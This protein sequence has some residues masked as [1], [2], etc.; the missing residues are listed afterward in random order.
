[1]TIGRISSIFGGLCVFLLVL[2]LIP[3]VGLAG[4]KVYKIGISTIATHP[5]LDAARKGFIDEMAA[6]GFEDGKNVAY[7]LT[8]AE[9][10]M[11]LAASIAKKFVSQKKDMILAIT[12]PISQACVAAAKN[13]DIPIV[14]NSVTDPVAAGIVASWEKP[15]GL[16]TGAS[17]WMDVEHQVR[18]MKEIY[19]SVKKVGVIFNAG[20]VNSQVQVGE[21]KKAVA[22]LGIEKVVEANVAT[23]ADVLLTTKSLVGRVD[24]IWFP[25]D[26]VVVAALEAVVKVCEDNQIPLFGS[27]PNQ[28]QRGVIACSGVSMY[29]VGRESGKMAAR[30]LNGEKPADIP[31]TKGVMSELAVNPSA[32]R[33]MG[34]TI[35]ETVM[36]KATEVVDK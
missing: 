36:A 7:E 33:R 3:G 13:T 22:K 25:T 10:D 34:V 8:N 26:N 32:A 18:L 4:E 9:G 1:M 20:E 15:G 29:D 16:V 27:D 30:I 35:P 11:S 6:Q 2:A 19:P 28:V 21:L 5:A 23:T 17:D 12:T 24:A 31:V 14:F